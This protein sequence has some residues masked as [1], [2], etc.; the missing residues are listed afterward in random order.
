MKLDS[1]NLFELLIAVLIF[2]MVPV[3]VKATSANAFTIGFFRLLVASSLLAIMWR[4]KIDFRAIHK[5]SFWKLIIIGLCFFSH[6]LTYTFSVKVGGPSFTV[7]GM[8]T[9]G[10]QLILY[11]SFFLGYHFNRKNLLCLA[12]IIFGIFLVVPNF[13]FHNKTTLGLGLALLS[14][15]FYAIIPIMLQKSYE[16]NQETR[17]FFQFTISLIGY[18]LLLPFADFHQLLQRDWFVLVFL[19]IFGTFIAHTLW[20]G[21]V[22]RLPTTTTGISYYLIT[23]SA[24]LIS[25]L[26]FKEDLSFIQ[27]LGGFI[28]LVSAL[29]N[30][31][32]KFKN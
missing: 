1:K 23:P 30:H 5:K 24:M 32:L 18:C 3:A 14:A 22:S 20:S 10:I 26:V 12:L 25:W 2:S 19:A 21:L 6:W 7:I 29:L 28:I 15:S 31:L 13:D 8:A 9:Y 27:I 16:F 11:G 4:K 17:V